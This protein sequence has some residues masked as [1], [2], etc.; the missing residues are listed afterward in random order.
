MNIYKISYC[1]FLF[2]II[3]SVI[4]CCVNGYAKNYYIKSA[5][6]LSELRLQAGDKVILKD[7]E[8]EN[9]HGPHVCI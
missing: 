9:Q 1:K 5:A 6:E 2:Q 4:F 7:V 3:L 8:W